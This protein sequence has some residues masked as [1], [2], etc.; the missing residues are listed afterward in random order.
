ME[1]K[2]I[3]VSQNILR[4]VS[5]SMYEQNI[6]GNIKTKFVICFNIAQRK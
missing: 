6:K 2:T 5:I 3:F 1:G 4:I